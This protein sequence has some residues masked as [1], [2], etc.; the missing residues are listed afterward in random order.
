M[1]N[2]SIGEKKYDRMFNAFLKIFH[3]CFWNCNAD[4]DIFWKSE[5]IFENIELYGKSEGIYQKI[6]IVWKLLEIL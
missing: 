3:A 5:L 1:I 6:E 4:C 2:V